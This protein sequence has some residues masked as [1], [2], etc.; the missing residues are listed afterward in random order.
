MI[1]NTEEKGKLCIDFDPFKQHDPPTMKEWF[2]EHERAKG[3]QNAF[4]MYAEGP[5]QSENDPKED[6][7]RVN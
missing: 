7:I 5:D 1:A 4:L 3:N 2:V 6:K